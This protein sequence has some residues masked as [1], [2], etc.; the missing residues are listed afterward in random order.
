PRGTVY[1]SAPRSPSTLR[2]IIV[3]P[4][5]KAEATVSALRNALASVDAR[6]P[7]SLVAALGDDVDESL[8]KDRF[9]TTILSVFAVVSLLLA[10]VG[11]Y[12]VFAG[13][14]A[15]RRKEVGI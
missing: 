3:R 7:L 4:A 10:G 11:I 1:L 5:G 13:D 6:L 9:T 2:D 12:G 14:V 15:A 8:A